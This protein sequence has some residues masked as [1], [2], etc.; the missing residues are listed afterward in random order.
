Y[1]VEA[2][3]RGG[4]IDH[5]PAL[6]V[7]GPDG[8]LSRLY[9]TQQSYAAVGQLG[10]QLAESA[11]ALLPGHP[12]VHARNS[13]SQIAGVSPST[14]STLPLAGGGSVR[15][16]PGRPRLFLFFATWDQEVT[17]LAGQLERL[18]QYAAYA[19]SKRLPALTA[20]DEGSVE[21]SQA[22]LTRFLAGLPHPLSYPVAIDP[23]G[24]IADG[25]EVEDL[26]WLM[27]VSAT[28]RI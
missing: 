26:P 1:G 24:R 22:T 13:Y 12:A 16:G 25:Y 3:V 5:T 2:A 11:S 15:L 28:G 17:S 7:I 20:V 19:P 8:R 18:N 10:Q 21:P 23:S 14:A 9:M 27:L 4:Q 6:F